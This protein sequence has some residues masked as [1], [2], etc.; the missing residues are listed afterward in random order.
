MTMEDHELF[1]NKE[2][3][4][5]EFHI[6]GL[7]PRID[8]IKAANGGVYLTHTEVPYDIRGAGIAAQLT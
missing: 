8:Y 7:I 5:Y 6:D 1:D 4:C 2:R 3:K